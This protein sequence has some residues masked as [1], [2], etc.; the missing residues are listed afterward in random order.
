[1]QNFIGKKLEDCSR[2]L[3]L[4]QKLYRVIENTMNKEGT[5]FVTNCIQD[6]EKIIITA[7]KF[8]L[9]NKNNEFV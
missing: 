9:R 6:K 8:D 5:L 7:S 1:M 3:D 2:V 4:S